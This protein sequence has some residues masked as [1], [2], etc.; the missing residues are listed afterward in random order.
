MLN[1]TSSSVN[2][3]VFHNIYNKVSDIDKF[4]EDNL[5]EKLRHLLFDQEA[6]LRALDSPD[7]SVR[8]DK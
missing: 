5:Y 8:A 3:K 6:D 1:A 2:D 4:N 7:Q